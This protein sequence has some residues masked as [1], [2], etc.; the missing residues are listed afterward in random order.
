M[1]ETENENKILRD[2]MKEHQ[3]KV[4][5]IPGA[6][7]L[8]PKRDAGWFVEQSYN[9]EAAPHAI[10]KTFKMP[11][12]LKIYDGTTDPED[13]V[14]HYVTAVK[15]NDLAKEQVPSILLKTFG[16]TLTRGALTWYSQL[17]ARSI[18]TF[19]EITDKFVTAHVGAKK[20]E[21]KVN[22]IFA[23][24]QAPGEGLRDFV[25]RFNR[26]R[27]T[28]PNVSEGMAV[29]A[30]QS[31]LNRNRSR[32]TRKL[33]SRLMNYPQPLG[34]KYTMPIVRKIVYAL[35]KL[36]PKVKRPQKMRSDPSTRKSNALCEFLQ[37][38]GHKI[39]DCIA[40]RR[41]V[42]NASPWALERV[43]ERSRKGQ[44]RPRT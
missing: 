2:Q 22:D 37:E 7:K 10:P 9:D 27:M 8:L 21:A 42:V 44:L 41:E 11:P 4:D 35:E 1:E 14:T 36:G 26:V 30:S 12:Y 3:E 19:E 39:E 16:E 38:R 23:I 6:P 13:L 34:V 40:L 28:L 33:L 29:A 31:G 25:A 15:G 20:V 17:P 43:T 18:G 24:K 5:K 32:A